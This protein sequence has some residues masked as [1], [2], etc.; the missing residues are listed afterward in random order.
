MSSPK[1]TP[2]VRGAV[3]TEN[4][5]QALA[6][7]GQSVW[8]D[9]IRRDLI[10]T[11]ELAR[12]I[13]E[14][15]L[16]GMTSNPSIFEKAIADSKEYAPFL[17]DLE[18][19]KGLD[20]TAVY[21]R[22]AV[23]DIQD[24]ADI[25]RQV[26]HSTQRRD[27]YVSLEVSPYLAHKTGETIDEAQRL[28]KTVGR[29]NVMIKVPGTPEG[30][31]A[32]RDLIGRGL[33]INV[34]LLFAQE[35]YREV[36][37][38]YIAGLEDLAA[39][40]G[41]V[42]RVASVASFF[43]SR[44]DTLVDG[45]LA[46]RIKSATSDSDRTLLQGL[47][48]K[49]AIAN[50]KMA[51]EMYK[52]IFSGPRWDA[53]AKRGAQTQRLLWAS[54]STK[55]PAYRDVM[56]VEELIGSPTVDTIPPATLDAFRDHG[57]P[58]ASLEEGVEQARQTMKDLATAG[59][60]M[61]QVTDQLTDEGVK[62]FAEAFDKLLAVVSEHAGKKSPAAEGALTYRLPDD[63]AKAVQATLDD[64]KSRQQSAAF[65]VWGRFAVDQHR[66]R[67]MAGL[68]RNCRGANRAACPV[69]KNCRRFPRRGIHSRAVAGHGRV[70][71]VRGSDGEDLRQ[72]RRR[73]RKCWC[74]IP[75]I[76][77]K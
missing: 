42:S 43:V 10:T 33:N 25:M 73:S 13:K 34:T 29:D 76:R 37:L 39:R 74:W 71:P 38:A 1:S 3:T 52:E 63:L 16:R 61:K 49:V 62:L 66:R 72:D 69:R 28:W 35:V 50:A 56:Y 54:T 18:K 32:I 5:L 4:P 12:L 57:R 44:I 14:D 64:W 60:S 15:G 19:E 31:P 2:D 47:Q 68:A 46:A 11:G 45:L 41:D 30:L 75:P 21:E 59:I 77:R 22:L 48:G 9:Y 36:A 8:L 58:R 51:Y 55:N 27:G 65:V 53:L 20:A 6:K 67:Q 23:R 40:G 7:F 70:E 26:Y 24:A 17:Q